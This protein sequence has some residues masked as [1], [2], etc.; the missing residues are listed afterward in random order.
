MVTIE[1]KQL[2]TRY[3]HLCS[4][5]LI[6]EGD[7]SISVEQF[8]AVLNEIGGLET[9]LLENGVSGKAIDRV[10]SYIKRNTPTD[11]TVR[12]MTSEEQL[13][14]CKAIFGEECHWEG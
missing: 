13:R 8:E 14:I 1:V 2:L 7:Q 3:I 5:F 9:K 11:N 4:W 6:R 10:I 12:K